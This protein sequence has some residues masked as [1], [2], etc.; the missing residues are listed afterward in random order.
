MVPI[1]RRCRLD[2]LGNELPNRTTLVLYDG[3]RVLGDG[4]IE[5]A[6]ARGDIAVLA[7]Y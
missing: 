1:V 4:V 7:A 6:N 2:C 3:E 5:R